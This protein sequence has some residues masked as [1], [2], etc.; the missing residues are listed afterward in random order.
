MR[1]L[2]N[3]KVYII[4]VNY[5][6]WVDTVECL[7]SL[8]RM[9]YDNY[10]IVVVDNDSRDNS[11]AYLKLWAEG[12][13][14]II[15]H[16]QNTLKD[17]SFPP[18]SKPVRYREYNRKQAEQGGLQEFDE[19]SSNLQSL[20]A[21]LVIINSGGNLGFAGGNN[22]G[23]RYALKDE[24]FQYAW[25]LNNDTV[26]EPDALK[27]MLERLQKKNSAGMCGSTLRY[28]FCPEAI[29][30]LGGSIYNKWMGWNRYLTDA[31]Q[32][33]AAPDPDIIERRLAGISGASM[34]VSR[35]FLESVGLMNEDY[36][37]YFEELDWSVRA[38]NKFTMA[39][40]PESVVY[41]KDGASIRKGTSG[42][43]PSILSEYY[44]QKNKITFTRKY[45]PYA[46]PTIYFGLFL[47]IVKSIVKRQ[48][49]RVILVL[50]IFFG[51][52][53]PL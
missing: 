49:D 38:E 31:G 40:A 50:K 46:L 20:S 48:W 42:N 29:Q 15:C 7:E 44:L 19:D 32:T 5:C 17:L 2:R 24:D 9:D 21:P 36:F 39:Y 4:L 1:S 43:K 18:V 33:A 34:L 22:V 52:R 30:T 8:L 47:A 3:P 12:K 37:L 6:G 51:F 16:H 35:F 14:D 27:K 23:L 28:Y 45:Y 25:I 10:R 41:H 11:I 26:V 13:L 53:S